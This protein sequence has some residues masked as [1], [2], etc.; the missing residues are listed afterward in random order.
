MLRYSRYSFTTAQQDKDGNLFLSSRVPFRYQNLPDNRV[1]I[2]AEGDTVFR[3]A[4]RY[5]LP[6]DEAPTLWDVICDFQPD[7][8]ID[9]TLKLRPGRALFIPSVRTVIEVIYNENRRSDEAV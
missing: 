7:P 5:F 9:P 6:L 8:I 3:L 4:H 2:I 1:H